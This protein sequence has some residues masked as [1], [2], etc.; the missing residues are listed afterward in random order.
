ML[1]RAGALIV[2]ED[3]QA[4]LAIVA[5]EDDGV[6]RAAIDR[7]KARGI[8][9]N[10][11]DRAADCDFTLPAIVDRDPVIV[12][13]GTGGASAGLAKALRQRLEAILPARLGV[14][15]MRLQ[16]ARETLRARYPDAAARRTAIDDALAEGGTLDP[17]SAS[18]YPDDWIAAATPLRDRTETIAVRSADPDDLTIGQARLLAQADCV[19]HDGRTASAILDRARADAVRRETMPETVSGLTVIVRTVAA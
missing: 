16:N 11:V 12:A 19:V 6:A 9:V 1:D 17:L 13:I 15:A 14:L 10:A 4:A 3:A 2:G 18:D 7:L 5:V 8:L